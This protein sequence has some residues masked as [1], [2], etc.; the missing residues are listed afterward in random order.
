MAVGRASSS[1]NILRGGEL[2]IRR[3]GWCSQTLKALALY[4]SRMYCRS[5][6]TFSGIGA[7]GRMAGVW[8]G[9]SRLGQEQESEEEVGTPELEHLGESDDTMDWM[10]AGGVKELQ[11]PTSGNEEGTNPRSTQ[12][13]KER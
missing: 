7:Q 6:G 1:T 8:G 12:A 5:R 3:R 10:E 2:S 4:L 9:S 13:E 11:D